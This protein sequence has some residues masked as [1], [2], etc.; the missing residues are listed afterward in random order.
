MD[1]AKLIKC[2]VTFE[3]CYAAV[4]CRRRTTV[5]EIVNHHDDANN[6]FDYKSQVV[7]C[8]D[9]VGLTQVPIPTKCEF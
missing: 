9:I 3:L 8:A 5:S 7:F 6:D 4:R 1:G 2:S